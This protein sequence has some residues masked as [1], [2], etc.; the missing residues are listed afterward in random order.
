LDDSYPELVEALDRV[1]AARFV[2]DG[3]IVAFEGHVTSFARLQ[4]RMQL[5]DPDAARSSGIRVYYY[6]FDLL[7]LDGYD[8]T[9]LPLERRKQL[10]REALS[11]DG[12]LRFTP[13]RRGDG[14]AY[15]AQACGK[16]WE[17]L[18]A[19]D[20]RA[21]YRHGR[22]RDWL[23]FKCVREQELVIGG[24]TDPKGS[25]TGFGALVVGFYKGDRLHYAGKVGTGFDEK[26]LKSIAKTLRAKERAT[27]PFAEKA[28]ASEKG[29]HWVT[30]EVVAQIAFSE[31][32]RD[33]RLRHPRFIGLRRDKP[34]R[35]VV[36]ETPRARAGT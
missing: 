20:A 3:E 29:V 8:L 35:K 14:E 32:T 2:A 34:A 4:G 23:K 33:D 21:G 22:S 17:G 6:L 26:T 15:F 9:R 13:H 10:L 19:K 31:W 18:I 27:C 7:H 12:P 16:G 5:S 36:K 11:F 30:P 25:R 24:Y 1:S 28:A